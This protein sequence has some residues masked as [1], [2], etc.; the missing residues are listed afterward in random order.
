MNKAEKIYHNIC[1]EC[2]RYSLTEWCEECG[3][4]LDDFYRFLEVGY[5]RFKKESEENGGVEHE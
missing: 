2:S 4:T 5:E 1:K 3:F